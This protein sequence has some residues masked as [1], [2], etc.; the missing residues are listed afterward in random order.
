MIGPLW[1]SFLVGQPT[2]G[3]NDQS[4]PI[5]ASLTLQEDASGPSKVHLKMKSCWSKHPNLNNSSEGNSTQMLQIQKRASIRRVPQAKRIQDGA[6]SSGEARTSN[7]SERR[8]ICGREGQISQ[9]CRPLSDHQGLNLEDRKR[10]R[11]EEG[12]EKEGVGRSTQ[13]ARKVYTTAG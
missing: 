1:S 7:A 6:R 4:G 8:D 10:N 5:P 11:K 12:R 9:A 3:G 13:A 2:G